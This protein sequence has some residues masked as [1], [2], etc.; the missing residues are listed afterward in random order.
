[1]T[2]GLIGNVSLE[3]GYLVLIKTVVAESFKPSRNKLVAPRRR[4][5]SAL[6]C[7]TSTQLAHRQ[8][9]IL[10]ITRANCTA[11]TRIYRDQCNFVYLRNHQTHPL[12][13]TEANYSI[14]THLIHQ[15]SLATQF[16]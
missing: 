13:F 7:S 1:M 11:Y 14:A 10:L 8:A 15:Q 2:Y 9:A 16:N 6:G 3:K 12:S 5:T 4:Y